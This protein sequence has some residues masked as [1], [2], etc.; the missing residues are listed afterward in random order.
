MT[1]SACVQVMSGSYGVRKDE[2]SIADVDIVSNH[3][4]PTYSFNLKKS[5][6]LAHSGDKVFI[7]GEFE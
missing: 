4:Y 6:N 1:V 2:L 5:A 3:F 7:N